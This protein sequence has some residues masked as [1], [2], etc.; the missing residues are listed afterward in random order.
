MQ[1]QHCLR[2]YRNHSHQSIDRSSVQDPGYKCECAP[3]F[4]EVSRDASGKPVC[5][6]KDECKEGLH[7]NGT[8]AC[9]EKTSD[10]VNFNVTSLVFHHSEETLQGGYEC[11]CKPGFKRV[12]GVCVDRDECAENTDD[13]DTLTTICNNTFGS[14]SSKI[15]QNSE[16]QEGTS[17]HVCM[18]TSPFLAI[19]VHVATSTSATPL[20]NH[21]SV[22]PTQRVSTSSERT[23][24][25]AM[26]TISRSREP[27]P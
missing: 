10:C 26:R 5:I 12:N 9:D 27:M 16:M 8:K 19:V 4:R 2:R 11:P 15:Q 17:V 3:G 23:S 18:A 20:S 25:S 7:G 14:F 22:F 24:A 1:Q 21:T 6:D 13:C